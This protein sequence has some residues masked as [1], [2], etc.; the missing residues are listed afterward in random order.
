MPARATS[1]SEVFDAIDI[2]R[3]AGVRAR[4]VRALVAS[5]AIRSIDGT[6]VAF[7]DAVDAVRRLRGAVPAE[8]SLAAGITQPA[9]TSVHAVGGVAGHDGASGVDAQFPFVGIQRSPGWP[10]AASA[11]MH[12]LL[13][14]GL[15][16]ASYGVVES[17]AVSRASE[18]TR[19]VYLNLPGPGGGGGG[20]GLRVPRPPSQA[21]RVGTSAV[22]SP[23]P[24]VRPAPPA[25]PVETPRPEPPQPPQVVAPV[26]DHGQDRADERGVLAPLPTRPSAG[27]GDGGGAGTGTGTG[28]GEGRGSGIGEGE[29]GGEGGGPYRPGSDIQPP[30]LLR[31]VKPDYTDDARRR[32]VQG[33]VELEIVIG[34]DGRVRS[35][36]ITRSLDR[37][38][39]Q[40]AVDAVRRWQFAP[41]TRRGQPVDIVVEVAVE[42]RLR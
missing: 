40:Q 7:A 33:E 36:R 39:D 4:D 6:Y 18:P 24:Y 25:P 42:F 20:G 27:P 41:A 23:V 32:G 37:G 11:V 3:A 21:R 31:D 30:R 15:L 17:T 38:L 12:T 16:L 28:M 8:M 5:G 22:Q 14:G 19:L 1:F 35:V 34:R 10:A 26:A 9:S 29:G 13:I 2:A